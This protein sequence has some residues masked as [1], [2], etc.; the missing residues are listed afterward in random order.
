MILRPVDGPTT[1]RFDDPRPL[2]NP[3]QHPHGA[4]DIAAQVGAP[5]NAPEAGDYFFLALCRRDRNVTADRV[6]WSQLQLG[7]DFQQHYYFYDIYGGIIILLA[8]SGRAHILA[9]SY[10]NQIFN[11]IASPQRE[12]IIT[13]ESSADERFPAIVGEVTTPMR[14]DPGDCIGY[15]GNAGYSTGA[16]VHWEVHPEYVWH[17]H[18]N[19]VDPEGLLN[20]RA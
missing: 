3:G 16:H 18:R 13:I 19:R 6:P 8:D 15:V 9:H 20:G 2:S 11:K 10:R 1:S 5:I 4:L 14:A 12:T 17:R 7:F